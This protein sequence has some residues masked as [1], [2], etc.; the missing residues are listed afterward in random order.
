MKKLIN[1]T[2]GVNTNDLEVFLRLLSA[3]ADEVNYP[4]L[5]DASQTLIDH[6][7]GENAEFKGEFEAWSNGQIKFK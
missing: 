3:Y 6:L 1:D 5:V 7:Y 2:I 4:Y